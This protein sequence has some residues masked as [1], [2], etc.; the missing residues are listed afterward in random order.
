MLIYLD[1]MI[2]QYCVDYKDFIFGDSSKCPTSEPKLRKELSALRRLVELEQ[3]GDWIFASSPQLVSELHAGSPTIDQVE[4]Y[5]LLRKSYEESGWGEAFHIEPQT[6]DRIGGFVKR[7]GL[8]P[9]DT[10]HLAEAITLNASW[11]LTN[12]KGIIS[13]CRDQDLP[14]RVARPSECLEDISLGLFVR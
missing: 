2:V 6:V 3:L 5:K 7:L 12:D 14:L 11:F 1:I 8:Q 13:R 9:A 10:R 4:I